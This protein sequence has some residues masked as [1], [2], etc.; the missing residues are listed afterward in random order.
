MR[1]FFPRVLTPLPKWTNRSGDGTI[2]AC[3]PVTGGNDD[4]QPPRASEQPLMGDSNRG[5]DTNKRKRQLSSSSEAEVSSNTS[6]STTVT[7][8]EDEG[9]EEE[10]EQVN[11]AIEDVVDNVHKRRRLCASTETRHT[12][13]KDKRPQQPRSYPSTTKQ[14]RGRVPQITQRTTTPVTANHSATSDDEEEEE[15]DK[16]E[17][18]TENEEEAQQQPAVKNKQKLHTPFRPPQH[19]RNK[20]C[21][22]RD[23]GKTWSVIPWNKKHFLPGGDAWIQPMKEFFRSVR[24]LESLKEEDRKHVPWRQDFEYCYGVHWP[25]R[26]L[27]TFMASEEVEAGVSHRDTSKEGNTLFV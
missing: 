1:G 25:V 5:S 3:R 26:H 13:T 15:E 7:N 8:E 6:T 27:G 4:K 10:N 12:L 2:A 14:T 18:E 22:S 9:E 16:D 17:E 11:D 23:R 24:E 20:P 19:L 21:V